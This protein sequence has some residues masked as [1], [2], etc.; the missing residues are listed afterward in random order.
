MGGPPASQP[1]DDLGGPLAGT[2]SQ[3]EDPQYIC[4]E[5]ES[6][7]SSKRGLGVHFRAAHKEAGNELIRLPAVKVR[8]SEEELRILAQKANILSRG[9]ASE[10]SPY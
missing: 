5:C 4:P 9:G 3:A 7:F 1:V 2:S 8:W 6:A 10:H